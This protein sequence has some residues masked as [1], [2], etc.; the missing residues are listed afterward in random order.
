MI[1]DEINILKKKLEEQ[2]MQEDSYNSI[3]ETSI[4]IDELLVSYY[5]EFEAS[6]KDLSC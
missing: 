6:R 3:Y 2:V 1:A 5:K 4:R